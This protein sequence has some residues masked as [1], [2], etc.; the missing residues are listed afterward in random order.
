VADYALTEWRLN[1]ELKSGFGPAEF[2]WSM[3]KARLAL[4]PEDRM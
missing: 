2:G 1:A 4:A 3:R